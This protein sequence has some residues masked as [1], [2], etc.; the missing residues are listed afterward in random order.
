MCFQDGRSIVIMMHVLCVQPF[1][2]ITFILGSWMS[3]V[4]QSSDYRHP[5]QSVDEYMKTLA[6]SITGLNI[7]PLGRVNQG[8]YISD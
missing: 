8:C 6:N 4:V 5:N 7:L 1:R 3:P 2:S